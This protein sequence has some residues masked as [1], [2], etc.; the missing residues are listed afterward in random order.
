MNYFGLFFSF[1]VPGIVIGV[2][3]A[4]AIYQ[5]SKARARRKSAVAKNLR[6]PA[7]LA[8]VPRNKLFVHDMNRAA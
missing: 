4:V 5:E 6:A 1:M 2:M 3:A 8:V 7:H